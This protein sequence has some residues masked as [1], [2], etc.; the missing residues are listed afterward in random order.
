MKPK[1]NNLEK[2]ISRLVKLAGDADKPS[3]EFVDSVMEDALD[4]LKTL[5]AGAK[6]EKREKSAKSKWLKIF[7]YAASILIVCGLVIGLTMPR[8]ERARERKVSPAYAFE[9]RIPDNKN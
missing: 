9:Q 6:R 1:E 5:G 4:E 2:N 8:L 7:A 3:G